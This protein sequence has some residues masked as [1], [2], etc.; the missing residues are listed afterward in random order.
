MLRLTNDR[1]AQ[2][3]ADLLEQARPET[4][5][6]FLREMAHEALADALTR[7]GRNRWRVSATLQY[8]ADRE[9]R[10]GGRELRQRHRRLDDIWTGDDD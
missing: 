6:A 5:A 8:Q 3:R 7:A 2:L 9:R 1:I 4:A 10:Q